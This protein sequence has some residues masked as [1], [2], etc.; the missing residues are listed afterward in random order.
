MALWLKNLLVV[1]ARFFSRR[2]PG[3]VEVNELLAL[4]QRI[5]ASLLLLLFP[6]A[7]EEANLM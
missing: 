6:V 4:E 7:K 2:N 1:S 3:T 5:R